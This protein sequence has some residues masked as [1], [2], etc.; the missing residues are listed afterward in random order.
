MIQS[1]LHSPYSVHINP[2]FLLFF[3]YLFATYKNQQRQQASSLAAVV[4]C[5][6][7]Y[8]PNNVYDSYLRVMMELMSPVSNPAPGVRPGIKLVEPRGVELAVWTNQVVL[9]CIITCFFVLF[10]NF[11]LPVGI[12][13][14]QVLTGEIYRKIYLR[15]EGK[16]NKINILDDS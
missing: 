12:Y 9:L 2:I 7:K 8:V 6:R 5:D 11:F 14:W 1:K 16:V 13:P 10:Q 4:D 3:E 15:G